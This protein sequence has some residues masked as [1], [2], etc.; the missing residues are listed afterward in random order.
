MIS[1]E[2]LHPIVIHFP[3]VLLTLAIAIDLWVLIR[4][5]DL[6]AHKGLA[7]VGL[8]SLV[9]GTLSAGLAAAFGDIAADIAVGRGFSEAPIENHE[10][11]AL[12]ALAIFVGYTGIRLVAWWKSVSLA[13]PRGW[14]AAGLGLAGTAVLITAAYYGGE[15]VYGL[16]IN[17]AHAA[18]A[19]ATAG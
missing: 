11:M 12:T 17:V 9:L 13:A 14:L 16:G 15:L 4:G 18:T 6:S 1:P 2:L 8:W 10:T 7:L 5:G 3:L 19:I